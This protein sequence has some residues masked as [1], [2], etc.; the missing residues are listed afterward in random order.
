MSRFNL[1]LTFFILL[2]IPNFLYSKEI[3]YSNPS[4]VKIKNDDVKLIKLDDENAEFKV[5]KKQETFKYSIKSLLSKYGY[6]DSDSTDSYAPSLY[7]EDLFRVIFSS[8][9]YFY[10]DIWLDFDM[11]Y[12][13]SSKNILDTTGSLAYKKKS[14]KQQS[15]IN[16]FYKPNTFITSNIRFE[17]INNNIDYNKFT[18]QSAK[19]NNNKLSFNINTQLDSFTINTSFFQIIRNNNNM[20]KITDSDNYLETTQDLYTG[21]ELS[22]SKQLLENI[23]VSTSAKFINVENRNSNLADKTPNY[24]PNKELNFKTGYLYKDIK[25][26]SKVTYVA[27]RY[28]DNLNSDNLDAYTIESVGAT[29]FTK[30]INEDVKVDFNVRNILNKDYYISYDTKGDLRNYT[31]NLSM[32]F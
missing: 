15:V 25:F 31:V 11:N 24:S 16:I 2:I 18:Y 26:I 14:I 13:D 8:R 29:F 1:L 30:L 20:Y 28:S 9:I 17:N 3:N 23:E 21:V 19:N 7:N 27:D 10:D 22:L 5:E 6:E 4:Y 12:K 32:E